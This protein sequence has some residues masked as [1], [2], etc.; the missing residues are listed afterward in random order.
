M[1]QNKISKTVGIMSKIKNILSTPHL[2]IL[3]YLTY[4]CIIWASPEKYS[5]WGFT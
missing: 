1:I 5:S 3:L 4:S 2:R